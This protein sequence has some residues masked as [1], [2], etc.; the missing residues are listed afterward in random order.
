M[1]QALLS[2]A[3]TRHKDTLMNQHADG[4]F[5]SIG[6]IQDELGPI[7]LVKECDSATLVKMMHRKYDADIDVEARRL[8]E[9]RKRSRTAALREEI[10]EYEESD[11]LLEEYDALLD[12]IVFAI[13]TIQLHGLPVLPG[14]A[15]VMQS[16]M[17][18]ER[19]HHPDKDRYDPDSFDL[20]KPPGWKPPDELLEKIIIAYGGE[21]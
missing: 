4:P 9:H 21:P 2:D 15:C 17:Q 18:K 5:P 1:K 12:L 6:Q 13:G 16:N 19:G 10:Q 11:T 14:F 7:S 8:P 3:P 20:V